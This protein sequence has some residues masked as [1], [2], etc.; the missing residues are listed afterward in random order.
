[1]S[2]NIS[3]SS[4]RLAVFLLLSLAGC[5]GQGPA[6]EGMVAVSAGPFTMGSDKEDTS[7]VTAE[8]GLT[9]PL[10][11]D[12]HPAH[13]VTLPAYFI[14]QHEVTN[15]RYQKFI[16]ATGARPPGHWVDGKPP[17]DRGNYPATGMNWYDADRY[18]TWAGKR[19]PTEAEWEKAARGPDGL[20]YPWGNDFDV[21][22]ANTGG[23]GRADLAPVGSYPQSRS[24]YGADDMAG[25]VWEW[26]ADWYQ[27]YPGSTYR[28]DAFGQ[29]FKV[30]RGGSWGG[31]GHYA[32]EYFYR[33]S[34]R[35]FSE[36][37]LGFPDAGLRCANGAHR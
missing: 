10:Y 26:V 9:K 12:E 13:P 20:D 22:K 34:H 17:A 19:L 23:S 6:P 3:T 16:E 11:Q 18:C 21:K 36:P 14:D 31:A 30:L 27:P 15:D 24:P 2:G 4:G 35:L 5:P 28:S 33:T 8:Y 1:M 7:G 37:E 29:K 25:N 32:L